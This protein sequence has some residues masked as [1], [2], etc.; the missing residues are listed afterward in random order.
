M[1]VQDGLSLRVSEGASITVNGLFDAGEATISSTG[2]GARWG[3]LTLG[4]STAAVIQLSGTQLIESAPALTVS[5][6]GSVVADDVFM[7]RSASDPL[8]VVESEAC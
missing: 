5:G 4:T 7:A 1:S 3:G 2:Y 6:L 8:L